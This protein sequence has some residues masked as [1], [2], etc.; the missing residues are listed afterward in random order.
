M[1]SSM[2]KKIGKIQ[3]K[4]FIKSTFIVRLKGLSIRPLH[5]LSLRE[6]VVRSR[7]HLRPI[8]RGVDSEGTHLGVG[9]GLIPCRWQKREKK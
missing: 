6:V 9:V 5:K 2:R 3:K 4:L 8:R 1:S 7:R